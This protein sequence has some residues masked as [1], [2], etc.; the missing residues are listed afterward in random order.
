LSN[1]IYEID[2]LGKMT[3]EWRAVFEQAYEKIPLNKRI[4]A[5][6]AMVYL[7]CALDDYETAA[8]FLPTKPHT[9]HE[10]TVAM[11]VWLR[12]K[13]FPEAEAVVQ[14]CQERLSVCERCADALSLR[15]VMES[16]CIARK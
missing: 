1:L 10:I 6:D 8:K 3:D 15:K 11:Q 13:R 14:I 12:L 7:H 5:R 4:Y 9:I 2:C 16:Y